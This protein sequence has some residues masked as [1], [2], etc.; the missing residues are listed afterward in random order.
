MEGLLIGV[1]GHAF[2]ALLVC[3]F[4]FPSLQYGDFAAPKAHCGSP[5]PWLL[6][7]EPWCSRY[8]Y[9]TGAD[10]HR[11][12]KRTPVDTVTCNVHSHL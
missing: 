3:F 12:P 1:L 2:W 5:F 8:N 7:I 9:Q 4:F 11:C 10:Q 6:P